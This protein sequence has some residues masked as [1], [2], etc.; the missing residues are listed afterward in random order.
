MGRLLFIFSATRCRGLMKLPRK[1]DACRL[2]TSCYA[3]N[4]VFSVMAQRLCEY[5]DP[6]IQDAVTGRQAPRETCASGPRSPRWHVS[7]HCLFGCLVAWL[8]CLVGRKSDKG[9]RQFRGPADKQNP[10]VHCRRASELA[11]AWGDDAG[12]GFGSPELTE[13]HQ[14]LL[15]IFAY[16]W[17]SQLLP[18][19]SYQTWFS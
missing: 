7:P 8:V 19:V 11:L 2:N 17:A 14:P 18:G 12:R 15:V 16:W 9:P 1:M 6:K 5:N 4:V 10:P 3:K 13:H